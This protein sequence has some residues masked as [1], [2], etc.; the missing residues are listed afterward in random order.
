MAWA[1]NPDRP[2]DFTNRIGA[3]VQVPTAGALFGVA[4]REDF[5]QLFFCNTNSIINDLY[6]HI[7]ALAGHHPK[8]Q[9]AVFQIASGRE[10]LTCIFDQVVENMQQDG[11]GKFL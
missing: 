5:G 4:L 10:R 9:F 6:A 2:T 1:F 11:A 7:F 3:V 8:E